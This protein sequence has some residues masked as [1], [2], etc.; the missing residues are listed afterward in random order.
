M[1]SG[2]LVI[3]VLRTYS[4]STGPFNDWNDLRAALGAAE[5]ALEKAS[6]VANNR[7]P[8]TR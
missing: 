8:P 5:H 2:S 4:Q 6:T 1:R 3:Q 7:L